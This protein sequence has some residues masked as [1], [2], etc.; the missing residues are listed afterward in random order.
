PIPPLAA[1]SP[2]SVQLN[3]LVY[4]PVLVN[5]VAGSIS[6]RVTWS[7]EK[8]GA[9]TVP[10]DAPLPPG[11][12]EATTESCDAGDWPLIVKSAVSPM[13]PFAQT[14]SSVS[15]AEVR[16]FVKVHVTSPGVAGTV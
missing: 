15:V 2:A 6:A 9:V 12:T 13:A 11:G 3:A 7:P 4:D 5:P 1:S 16:V 14:F 10:V 8:I